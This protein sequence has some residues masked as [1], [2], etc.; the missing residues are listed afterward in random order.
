MGSIADRFNWASGGIEITKPAT[1]EKYQEDESKS[2]L[3][4]K[5]GV[6]RVRDPEYWGAPYDS[7]ITPG[8]RAAHREGGAAAVRKLLRGASKPPAGRTGGSGKRVADKPQTG[9][10]G[11]SKPKAADRARTIERLWGENMDNSLDVRRKNVA[12]GSNEY[13]IEY[14]TN[15]E[16]TKARVTA[17]ERSRATPKPDKGTISRNKWII[18]E[19]GGPGTGGGDIRGDA[20]Q[21]SQRSWDVYVAFGGIDSKGRDKGYV[22]CL[23]CGVKMSWHDDPE[24]TSY[25]KFEHDKIITTGDGGSYNSQNV[26]P[27]CAG[28]NNQR[29][30][31]KFWEAPQLRPAKPRWYTPTFQNEVAR[32]RANK[33]AK[34]QR[35]KTESATTPMPVPPGKVRIRKESKGMVDRIESFW[36]VTDSDK[37]TGTASNGDR[38]RAQLWNFDGRHNDVDAG[39]FPPDVDDP[40]RVVVG[41]LVMETVQSI[42]GTYERCSV[43]EDDGSIEWIERGTIEQVA[44]APD[45][46]DDSA[47]TEDSNAGGG[48]G[49]GRGS[50]KE[51]RL[52]DFQT[53]GGVRR[54]RS[55]AGVARYG[56]PIGSVIVA[57]RVDAA[58]APSKKRSS[59]YRHLSSTTPVA[60]DFAKPTMTQKKRFEEVLGKQ[61]MEFLKADRVRAPIRM[62]NSEQVLLARKDGLWYAKWRLGNETAYADTSFYAET[63]DEALEVIAGLSGRYHDRRTKKSGDYD[64]DGRWR[65]NRSKRDVD[66]L[67]AKWE[68]IRG[69]D[70]SYEDDDTS[71]D[72]S[73]RLA[74]VNKEANELGYKWDRGNSIYE[75]D[76]RDPTALWA[77]EFI[78]SLMRYHENEYPGFGSL[79]DSFLSNGNAAGP[80]AVAWNGTVMGERQHTVIGLNPRYFGE[81]AD[82]GRLQGLFDSADRD[83]TDLP[84]HAVD[85]RKLQKETGWD[86]EQTVTAAVVTHELGHTVGNILQNRLWSNGVYHGS[87]VEDPNATVG[88]VFRE[89]LYDLLFEYGVMKKDVG[90]NYSLGNVYLNDRQFPDAEYFDRQALMEQLSHYGSYNMAEMF[91]ETWA[92]YQLD[93]DPTQFVMDLGALMEDALQMFLSEETGERA[94]YSIKGN[95]KGYIS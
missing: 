88:N 33:N 55:A 35:P 7:P 4:T 43:V 54:V 49:G 75:Q 24:Y 78:N 30:T 77:K 76:H 28:C 92:A 44:G 57:D 14:A 29:G 6:R 82:G 62:G 34:Y 40:S 10:H 71:D 91:A 67:V 56:L 16:V 42:F 11:R 9:T 22:P 65:P 31:K 93:S 46:E 58:R 60:S 63:A 70:W 27:M 26:V 85:Y 53:K 47:F 8:M 1:D 79:H 25:P 80:F 69:V 12:R 20:Y 50:N 95:L 48:G 23:G 3:D 13:K 41:R 5:A 61:R 64:K 84:W 73:A 38:I 39:V 87:N 15:A 89:E 59:A 86:D 81:D 51:Q 21:R 52:V 36:Q 66:A 18:K 19:F 37:R 17:I 2:Y 72:E 90:T 83:K 45:Y 94:N 74:L 68:G 32:T